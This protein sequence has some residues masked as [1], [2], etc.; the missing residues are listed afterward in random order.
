MTGVRSGFLFAWLLLSAAGLIAQDTTVVLLRHAERQSIFDGDSPLAEAGRRRADALVPL[1]AGFHPTAL[2]TS[3]LQRTRQTLAP[4]AAKLG[5][6]PLVRPKEGSAAL[7]AEI[8]RNQRGRTVVV[9]WH[10]DL[11]KKVVR[12]LGVK[13]PVPYWSLD[14]YDRLWIVTIPA[15][16]EA[17]LV[18]QKQQL[19]PALATAS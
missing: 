3:E 4:T 19:A 14:I 13:G 9:V 17:R 12:A 10:H 16:G 5:L 18:E 11:M 1:L 7:A 2:Y 6:V 8:L 15:Q